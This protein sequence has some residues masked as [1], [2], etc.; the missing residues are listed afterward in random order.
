M[1]LRI[2]YNQIGKLHG[3]NACEGKWYWNYHKGWELRKAPV[4]HN[5]IIG[6]TYHE[7]V[8]MLYASKPMATIERSCSTIYDAKVQEARE[9]CDVQDKDELDFVRNKVAVKGML[10]GY[11]LR[12]KLDLKAM[13]QIRNEFEYVLDIPELQ[14]AKIMIK[15][16]NII[17][18]KKVWYVHEVKTAKT[19]DPKYVE[20]KQYDFQTALYFHM[21]NSL[22]DGKNKP[23]KGLSGLDSMR[24]VKA[25]LYD[26]V[27]K[28]QIRLK[29]NENERQFLKRLEVF[30]T[31]TDSVN[32]YFMEDYHPRLS[33][34]KI[35]KTVH[36]AVAKMRRI[37]E[38]NE[39]VPSFTDC[40]WCDYQKLCH[41]GGETKANLAFYRKKE[42]R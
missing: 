20:N 39:F 41:E 33:Y 29:K 2:S 38:S 27:Q 16:D 15:V 35:L 18:Y 36:D 13:K 37:Q 5:F 42:R 17:E 14:N 4:N 12:H 3:Y 6:G 30:Y 28:P 40:A 22:F 21:Y 32:K 34:D 8:G 7:G 9:Q 19:V 31:G 26:A 11:A 1:T 23:R 25:I 10:R 24:P